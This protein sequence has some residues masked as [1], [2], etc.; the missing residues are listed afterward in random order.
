MGRYWLILLL[1]L[2]AGCGA[3][4]AEPESATPPDAAE[5]TLT[6]ANTLITAARLGPARLGMTLGDLKAEVEATYGN[7][8]TFVPTPNFMVDLGAIAVTRGDETLFHVL[9]FAGDPLTDNDPITLLLTT[10]PRFKTAAG[11]GPGTRLSVA[12]S[13]YGEATLAHNPDNEMRESAR[14]A[15]FEPL[16]V[17]FRTNGFSETDAGLAGIYGEPTQGSF[18]ETTQ[19]RDDATIRAVMLDGNRLEAARSP[20]EAPEPTPPPAASGTEGPENDPPSVSATYAEVD[21][22]L[23]Q[24]YSSAMNSLEGVAQDKLLAAQ[25]RWLAFRNAECAFRPQLNIAQDDCLVETTR[26]RISQLSALETDAALQ[27]PE[28][29]T[30]GLGTVTVEGGEDTVNCDD[31]QGG[32]SYRYCVG[33]GYEREDARLNQIYQA[34]QTGPG[35]TAKDSLIDAQ[36]AWIDF[37]DAHCTSAVSDAYGGTGYN[38]YFAAC[39]AKLT[40]ARANTLSNYSNLFQ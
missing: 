29:L 39:Q 30:A 10:N 40:Q 17:T 33:L 28:E 12:E 27:I 14:F 11:V 37:R 13:V 15:N 3:P 26:D 2:G 19:Y 7:G 5:V 4:P 25:Q 36:L 35:T 16:S 20:V 18:Y 1:L 6:E 8:V 32:P 34:I 21:A 23:N 9:H 31:L 38:A 24:T 22:Q